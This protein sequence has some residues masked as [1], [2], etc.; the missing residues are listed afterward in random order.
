MEYRKTWRYSQENLRSRLEESPSKTEFVDHGPGDATMKSW[1]RREVL[2]W[3]YGGGSWEFHGN[4]YREN[5]GGGRE[6][7]KKDENS[8]DQKV[9]WSDRYSIFDI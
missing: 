5:Q 3:E 7:S 6:T 9:R 8:K 1:K 2:G 4:A